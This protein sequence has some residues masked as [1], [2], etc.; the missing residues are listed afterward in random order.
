MTERCSGGWVALPVSVV[1]TTY[2]GPLEG[3][4]DAS[5]ARCGGEGHGA[6][7]EAAR[8]TMRS[9]LEVGRGEGCHFRSGPRPAQI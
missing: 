2:N 6:G 9:H 4:S 5:G 3:G 1:R 8:L 7:C